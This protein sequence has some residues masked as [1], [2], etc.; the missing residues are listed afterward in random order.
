MTPWSRMKGVSRLKMRDRRMG[1]AFGCAAIGIMCLFGIGGKR[2]NAEVFTCKDLC[3]RCNERNEAG[4]KD[5]FWIVAEDTVWA[6]V[7]YR[8]GIPDGLVKAY[9]MYPVRGRL[10][11]VGE[12]KDGRQTGV[13]YQFSEGGVLLSRVSE[14]E[15]IVKEITTA[16]GVKRF[17]MT[18][19]EL[20]MYYENGMIRERGSIEHEE[21]SFELHYE[22]VGTW[23]YYQ[24]TG[25][26][27][28]IEEHR[29]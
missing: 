8:N 29:R 7:H 19:S 10:Q 20:V 3:G 1:L 21:G 27:E 23:R 15:A 11:L 12:Y 22:K 24:S 6:E 9:Y 16:E 18:R 14:F 2:A 5:G 17:P 4:N 28:K 25:E 13:W 26:L